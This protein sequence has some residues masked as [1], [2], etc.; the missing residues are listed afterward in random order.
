MVILLFVAGLIF[1]I[2]G[3]EALVRGSSRLAAVFGISPLVIGL[4]VVAFGTSS[5]EL[6][7][8]IKAA[9]SDQA[10]IAV[11][12]VIGS[13]IFNVLFILGLSALIVPLVVSHQLVRLDVP[14]MVAL[15]V[16]VLVFALDNNFS[17]TEGLTLVAV[18]AIYT[19]NGHK[20]RL[21]WP[22]RN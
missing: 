20:M 19:A 13:N 11:G 10:S 18:L 7:V 17:R 2:V 22:T 4:T 12:N 3:A 15:S 1:L 21:Y 16:I 6:A 8:S 5:P 9:L 14:L